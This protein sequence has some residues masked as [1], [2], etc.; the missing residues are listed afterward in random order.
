LS[1]T[2]GMMVSPGGRYSP[3]RKG[4]QVDTRETETKGDWQKYAEVLASQLAT[5]R[6][7]HV[8][9]QFRADDR[10]QI[11]GCIVY[12]LQSE[13]GLSD[14]GKLDAIGDILRREGYIAD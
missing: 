10:A 9:A 7:F 5:E 1:N 8:S 13:K 14:R 11:I 4:H 6:S 2:W 3:G 12:V